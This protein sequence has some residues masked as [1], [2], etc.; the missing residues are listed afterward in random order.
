MG[1]VDV[2]NR[3]KDMKWD[4]HLDN[5]WEELLL[6]IEPALKRS[7]QSLDDDQPSTSTQ[8]RGGDEH[9]KV[10]KHSTSTKFLQNEV[11]H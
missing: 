4:Q 2:E 11:R 1:D 10:E 7:K 6:D 3:L 9:N 5:L 8:S